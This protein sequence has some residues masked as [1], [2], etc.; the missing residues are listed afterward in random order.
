MPSFR[1]TLAVLE[2]FPGVPPPRVLEAGRDGVRDSGWLVEDAFVDVTALAS[3][4]GA[5]RITIR[6]LVPG[7]NDA[8]EDAGAWVV[9]RAL[10][11]AVGRVARWSDLRVFRRQRGQWVL[12]EGPLDP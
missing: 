1:A 3:R 2:A 9:A 12:L 4:R 11:T 7:S 6:F 8:S 10:A 5:P